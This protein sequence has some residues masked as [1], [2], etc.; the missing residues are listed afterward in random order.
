MTISNSNSSQIIAGD[1]TTTTFNFGFVGDSSSVI[2]VYYINSSNVSTLLAPGTYTINLN[3]P[4]TNQIWGVGGTITYPLTGSAIAV[5]TY[6]QVVRSVPYQQNITTQNQG[7]FYGQVIEQAIDLLEMQIQQLAARTTQ[8][9]GTWLTGTK[10]YQG[11]IVQDGA[12]GN[13]TLNYYICQTANTSGTWSTDLANGDWTVS[14][15]ASVPTGNLT[16]TGDVTGSGTSP[17]ATTL[18][19]VNSDVGSFTNASITVNA[20]GLVTAASTGSQAAGTVTSVTYTG[21]GVLQSSTPST[22]VTTSGTVTATLLT[23][24]KNT[25][26]AG[27]SSGSNADPTFRAL[28][29]ADIPTLTMTAHG[30]GSI[31]LGMTESGGAVSAGSTV[32]GASLFAANVPFNGSNNA[33]QLNTS[34]NSAPGDTLSGT[35]QALQNIFGAYYAGLWQRTA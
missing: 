35:W 30:V 24:A 21:D 28:V 6:L 25:V 8:F 22:A 26:L 19:T 16:L 10:Y 11:D 20:K 34:T 27:P 12:H 14:V 9:R 17:I 15:L 29:A 23:Q 5:G 2:S 1:G 31:I 18:A 4:A 7:N 33:N 32:S 13:D 3:A